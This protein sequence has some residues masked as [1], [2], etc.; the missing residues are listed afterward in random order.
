MNGA[1]PHFRRVPR[2]QVT[3]IGFRGDHVEFYFNNQKLI[4]VHDT[5]F[6]APGKVGVWTKADSRTLFDNLTATPLGP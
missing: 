1:H 5:R 3:Q 6:T 4:D 2:K